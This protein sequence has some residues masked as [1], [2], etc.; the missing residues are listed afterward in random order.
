MTPATFTPAAVRDLQEAVSW[1]AKDNPDAARGFRHSIDQAAT[2]LGEHPLIGTVRPESIGQPYRCL[3]VRGFHYILIYN[4]Q[5]SPPRI[6]RIL[7]ASRDLPEVLCG[8]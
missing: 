6:V 4:A 5:R 3:V 8:L 2:L 7:H 1:I